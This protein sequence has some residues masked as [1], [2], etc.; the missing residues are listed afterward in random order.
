MRT[1][2]ECLQSVL[3]NGTLAP[4]SQPLPGGLVTV[5]VTDRPPSQLVVAWR[6]TTANPLIRSFV[7]IAVASYRSAARSPA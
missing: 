2:Q 6:G 1:I 3:W 5:P 4:L 7:Q